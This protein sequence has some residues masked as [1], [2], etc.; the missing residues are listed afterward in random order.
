MRGRAQ[1][2][3]Q[4]APYVADHRSEPSSRLASEEA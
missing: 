4:L 2:K 1:L 3:A